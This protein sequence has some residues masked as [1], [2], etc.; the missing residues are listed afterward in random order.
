MSDTD[1]FIVLPADPMRLA[2]A[3]QMVAT[4]DPKRTAWLR[5]GAEQS[6]SAEPTDPGAARR[7]Q[8]VLELAFLVASA[9]GLATAERASLSLLLESMIDGALDHATLE[10]HFADLDSAVAMFGRHERLARAASDVSPD[11]CEDALGLA[12]IVALGD[13]KLSRPELDALVELGSHLGVNEDRVRDIARGFAARVQ[14]RL[15]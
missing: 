4:E 14:E 7:F 13:G 2:A 3:V 6:R 5:A 11:A 8:T 15:R 1:A 12:T 10:L 9:D